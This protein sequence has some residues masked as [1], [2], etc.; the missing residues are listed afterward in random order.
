V[1]LRIPAT[2]RHELVHT[3]TGR[4][5]VVIAI[6]TALAGASALVSVDGV[7]SSFPI[8]GAVVFY[9]ADGAY[10]ITGWAFDAGG[11]PVSGVVAQFTEVN[12]SSQNSSG[13]P[14]TVTTNGG[15]EFSLEVAVPDTAWTSLGVDSVRLDSSRSVVVLWGGIFSGSFDLGYVPL[16]LASDSQS[17]SAVGTN[18]YS[19]HTQVMVFLEGPGGTLPIGYHVETCYTSSLFGIPSP[20]NCTGLPTEELGAVTGYW[21]HVPLPEYPSNAS[22]IFVHVVNSTGGVV[23]LTTLLL[24][25]ATGGSSTVV[26]NAPGE[27][28]LTGFATEASFFVPA[29]AL[30]AG[31]WV[32]SRPRLSGSVEPVLAQPV[33]R[34]GIFLVRYASLASVLTIAVV[35]DVF[36]LDACANSILG[37]PLPGAYLATL[38][39]SLVVAALGFLGLV[40]LIAH[41]ARTSGAAIGAGIGVLALGFFWSSVLLG[42]LT[43]NNPAFQSSTATLF[44]LRSQLLLPPQF[45]GLSASLLIGVSPFGT[46][47]GAA[48][49]GVSFALEAVAGI[50]W[51]LAPVAIAFWLAVTRD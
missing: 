17:P 12:T 10:H 23:Q 11:S 30:V 22:A 33:T 29:M 15:G 31:Y 41:I 32:Y 4:A 46:P 27:S 13:G 5:V 8:N 26:N 50:A 40:F 28:I 24:S 44:L 7:T 19:A 16:G 9:Y 47:L 49:G 6:L 21:T 14:Y 37:E 35:V 51:V 45:P 18:F 48:P 2:Y 3:F 25:R 1:R 39:G 43:L 36:T 34:R 20:P 42:L 38:I